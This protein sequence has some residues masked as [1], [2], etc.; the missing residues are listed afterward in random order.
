M[1][2]KNK[3]LCEIKGCYEPMYVK[4]YKHSVCKLHWAKYCDSNTF[5]LK[6]VFNIVE[7]EKNAEN[8]EKG[9]LNAF[10]QE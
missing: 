4:Y 5:N 7:T 1:K 2:K 8:E 9:Y 10:I 3:N 6:K